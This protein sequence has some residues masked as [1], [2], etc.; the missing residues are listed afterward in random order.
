MSL[1]DRLLPDRNPD[2]MN[3]WCRLGL[4]RWE[5]PGYPCETCGMHDRLWS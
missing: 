2:A 4:H 5:A 1:L 3:V